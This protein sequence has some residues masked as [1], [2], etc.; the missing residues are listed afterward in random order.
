MSMSQPGNSPQL[1][2]SESLPEKINF[3]DI[4]A[5]GVNQI[6]CCTPHF[7]KSTVVHNQLENKYV[8]YVVIVT[9]AGTPWRVLQSCQV[10]LVEFLESFPW[11]PKA[12]AIQWG[13]GSSRISLWSPKTD[14]IWWGG[15]VAGI[16]RY[17]QL[18]NQ[19]FTPHSW[20]ETH[21]FFTYTPKIRISCWKI[22]YHSN[23]PNSVR[24]CNISVRPGDQEWFLE[25][26]G[27]SVRLGRSGFVEMTRESWLP[28]GIQK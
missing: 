12:D 10:E 26:H 2:V 14:A 9:T 11:S 24:F 21:I 16:F 5:R 1:S 27:N 8:L 19:M 28:S 15:V 3:A 23:W 4:C 13:G 22:K 17:L 6:V 25:T 20:V 7:K 18:R